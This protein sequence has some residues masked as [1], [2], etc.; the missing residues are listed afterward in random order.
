M[1]H[2]FATASLWLALAILSA[3]LASTLRL[4]IALVEICVGVAAAATIETFGLGDLLAADSE[5]V[6]F[7]AA[8]G[9]MPSQ[10]QY[11]LLVAAVIAS[12]VVPTAVAG[13]AFVPAHL[14]P[15]ARE[16]AKPVRYLDGLGDEG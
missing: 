4:S 8:T 1:E 7:L 2:L 13:M 3:L 6:R 15:P 11:P 16:P 10:E 9:A 14:L 12:A 5:W